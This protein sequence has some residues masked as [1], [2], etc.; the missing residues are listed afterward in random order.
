[1]N[2]LALLHKNDSEYAFAI[3]EHHLKLRLR[4]ERNDPDI[5]AI[6]VYWNISN[7]I[8]KVQNITPM[9]KEFSDG[10]FDYY[11]A[12]LEADTP[13]Y[14]YVFKIDLSSGEARYYSDSGLASADGDN[15]RFSYTYDFTHSD[16]NSFRMGW[17]HENDIIKVNQNFKG[18]VLYEIFPDRFFSASKTIDKS[19]VNR[20][21]NS[22]D[23]MVD[24]NNNKVHS[25]FLGGD[26]EGVRVKLPYLKELGVGAIYMTP[27]YSSNTNHRYD[28]LDYYEIDEKLGKKEDLVA[29]VKEAHE[30]GI[31]VVLDVVFNHSSMYHPFFM[32]VMAKGKKSKYFDW[33][34]INGDYPVAKPLNY[35]TFAMVP[36]MP[37]FNVNNPKVQQYFVEVATH[38]IR[39][40]DIDGFRL[41]VG[42]EVAHDFWIN[43]KRE[44]K[45]IKKDI[46]IIGECFYDAYA[47]LNSYEWDTVMNYPFM[48]AEAE[49][50]I[51]KAINATEFANHLNGLLARYKDNSNKMMLNMIN[52]HD[53]ERFYNKLAP[54][55]D[56]YLLAIAV[57]MMYVG[58]PMIYYGDEIFMTGA[59]D[60][61]NR[62]GMEWDSKEFKEE[63]HQMYKAL[64]HLRERESVQDGDIR[65]YSDGDLFIIE[66][67]KGDEDIVLVINNTRNIHNYDIHDGTIL[68]SNK[69]SHKEIHPH[70]FI[71]YQK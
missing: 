32:D 4:T 33:Y 24:F 34:V 67:S 55:K 42:N 71:V 39:T 53:T 15:F 56:I 40:Y 35:Y 45:R 57:Q 65:I 62:R 17:I 46:F 30:L 63:P 22:G 8:A 68:V 51:N 9:V 48:N 5:V 44:L 27:I 1:M 26:L 12:I 58:L 66:R 41:D 61:M 14:S 23:L 13:T 54:H 36:F 50:F 60:P 47:F 28:V 37:K 64:V 59:R 3:D 6:S 49:F 69:Y 43:F 19:F 52:S 10:L 29:L 16:I 7:M 11:T 70:G 31:R 25:P 21:W 38:F 20:E 2:I 18:K